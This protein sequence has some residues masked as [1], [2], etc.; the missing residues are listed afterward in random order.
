MGFKDV[1]YT[2]RDLITK[3]AG[4]TGGVST[5]TG[6]EQGTP[7]EHTR[8]DGSEMALP[9][10]TFLRTFLRIFPLTRLPP[11]P[12]PPPSPRDLQT[13]RL[14]KDL[15]QRVFDTRRGQNIFITSIVSALLAIGIIASVVGYV[16]CFSVVQGSRTSKGPLIWLCLESALSIIR[17]LV[18]SSNPEKDD[19]EPFTLSIKLDSFLLSTCNHP[20]DE[21]R[22]GK[23]LPLVRAPEF[24]ETI[25]A[26]AGRVERFDHPNLSLFYTL[27][28]ETFFSLVFKTESPIPLWRI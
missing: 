1:V 14:L 22:K 18:W 6:I 8:E 27:A 3:C 13:I 5:T 23:I 12:H 26:Y 20:D 19:L 21:L 25:T 24:L 7:A 16:G 4:G 11:P 9:P 28:R 10:L 2:G 17:I 15:L